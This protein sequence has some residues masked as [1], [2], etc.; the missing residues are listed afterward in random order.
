MKTKTIT[1]PRCG[2]KIKVIP[3][4]YGEIGVCEKCGYL[5]NKGNKK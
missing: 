3:Y 2:T 5:H 1:C 4:G